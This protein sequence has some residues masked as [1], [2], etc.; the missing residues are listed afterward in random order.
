MD[1]EQL[2]VITTNVIGSGDDAKRTDDLTKYEEKY[3]GITLNLMS[4]GGY[5]AS[6]DIIK[7]A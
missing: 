3:L 5:T 7:P 6:R 1:Y 4:G 2:Y